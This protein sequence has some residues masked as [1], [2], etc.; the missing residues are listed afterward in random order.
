MEDPYHDDDI[1]LLVTTI[2]LPPPP[3]NGN[4]GPPPPNWGNNGPPPNGNQGDPRLPPG[5][6]NQHQ[7]GHNP[8]RIVGIKDFG[9]IPILG[10]IMWDEWKLRVDGTILCQPWA[11]VLF[12][13]DCP[14]LAWHTVKMWLVKSLKQ[15]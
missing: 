8:F 14:F 2:T 10:E 15:G 12:S 7:F 9:N 13:K 5:F 1:S 4:N 11:W 3:N 6:G